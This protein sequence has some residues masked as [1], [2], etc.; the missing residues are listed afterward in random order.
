MKKKSTIE[1]TDKTKVALAHAALKSSN[2]NNTKAAKKLGITVYKLKKWM[3]GVDG[4]TK[5]K[6]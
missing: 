1:M 4:S 3:C 5:R 6:A 2:N